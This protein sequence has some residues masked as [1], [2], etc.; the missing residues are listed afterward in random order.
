ML[1]HARSPDLVGGDDDHLRGGGSSSSLSSGSSGSNS[2]GPHR[3]Q[4]ANNISTNVYG[5]VTD[6]LLVRLQSPV[7]DGPRNG[8]PVDD[9]RQRR[10][11]GLD[12]GDDDG[13]LGRGGDG[14]TGI[15][16]YSKT[17]GL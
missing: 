3:A 4:P 10:S 9:S 12:R 17:K 13:L 14:G 16:H 15:R 5:L 8:D 6:L 1:R 11:P 2:G 7:P